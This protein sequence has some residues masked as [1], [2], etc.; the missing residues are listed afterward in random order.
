MT[1][2]KNIPSNKFGGK[3]T[4]LIKTAEIIVNILAKSELVSNISPGI[5]SSYRGKNGGRRNI[6][7]SDNDSGIL[8]TV[9]E[10][11]NNQRVRIYTKEIEPVKNLIIKKSEEKG[12]TTS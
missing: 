5:I 1:K 6:K 12:F 3:H 10:N 4:S 2:T 8:I 11:S 7:I 9:T